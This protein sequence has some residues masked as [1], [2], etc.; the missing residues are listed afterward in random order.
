MTRKVEVDQADIEVRGNAYI[1]THIP[2]A[3]SGNW[4]TIQDA[5]EVW[6]AVAI[7][8]DG[9]VIGWRNPPDES[10]RSE[11]ERAIKEAFNLTAEQ[12]ALA[13]KWACAVKGI[14]I[15]YS[16]P[17]PFLCPNGNMPLMDQQN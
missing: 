4:Y 13:I 3:I 6:A 5:C 7:D 12:K 11:I 16:V 8:L 2:T 1:V 14:S 10:H 17:I 9:T 15:E